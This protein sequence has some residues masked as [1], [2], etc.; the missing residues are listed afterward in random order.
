M[1]LA[2]F[3]RG[4]SKCLPKYAGPSAGAEA[5]RSRKWHVWCPLE[6]VNT[7]PFELNCAS[8]LSSTRRM[9]VF[10]STTKSSGLCHFAL[11]LLPINNQFDSFQTGSGQTGLSQKCHNFRQVMF[12]YSLDKIDNLV[13]IIA[14]TGSRRTGSPKIALRGTKGCPKEGV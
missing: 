10:R 1:L 8:C 13:E 14:P 5:A 2:E 3:G 7:V 6:T 9:C 12:M 11:R 4:N